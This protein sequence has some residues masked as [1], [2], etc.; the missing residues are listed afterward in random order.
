[1]NNLAAICVLLFFSVMCNK[2]YEENKRNTERAALVS[3]MF[4]I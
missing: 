2:R 4:N 1:M 3:C